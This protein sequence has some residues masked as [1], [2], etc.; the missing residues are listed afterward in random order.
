MSKFRN[1]LFYLHLAC[2]LI[3]GVVILVMCVTG[4]LLMYER[5]MI[6]YAEKQV[7]EVKGRD[8][9][10][11]LPLEQLVEAAQ[12]AEGAQATAV[13]ISSAVNAPI[14]VAFGRAKSLKVNPYDGTVIQSSGSRTR[15]FFRAL[16]DW[17]RWLAASGEYR[18]LGKGVT[19]ASNLVFLFLTVSG[20][21]LWWPRSW[22]W[23]NLRSIL[24]F[25]RGLRG[26]RRDFNLHNT[27]GFWCCVPLVFIIVS[28]AVISYP[29]ASNLVFAAV[30]E[31][32]PQRRGSGASE[33]GA[34]GTGADRTGASVPSAPVANSTPLQPMLT[35]AAQAYPKYRTITIQLP[36][37]DDEAAIINVDE[38]TGGQPQKRTKLTYHL[39]L[40]VVEKVEPFSSG[41][42]GTRLR[43]LLR[44]VHTGEVAGIAGQTLAGLASAGGAFLVYTG[45]ALSW[46]RF[47]NWRQSKLNAGMGRGR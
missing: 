32:P 44:Y 20:L 14:E 10:A 29:W 25:R 34:R 17:H 35:E 21:L 6:A 47:R 42:L 18:S 26:H 31:Q 15:E 5:Q 16:R 28:G 39:D 45:F 41:S 4:T 3:A 23:N 46:R 33:A 43:S 27:L 19:G 37:V 36:K 1:V 38:G 22:R 30:G 9:A 12:K 7:V 8:G 24:W 40:E 11:I 13:A 2:G